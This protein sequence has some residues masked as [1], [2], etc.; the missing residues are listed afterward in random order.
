MI[1][2]LQMM[3]IQEENSPLD[4]KYGPVNDKNVDKKLLLLEMV[5]NF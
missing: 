3:Y 5:T 1:T 2:A 4:N